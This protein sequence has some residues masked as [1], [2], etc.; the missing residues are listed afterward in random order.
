G[1]LTD[2]ARLYVVQRATG[3]PTAT[4]SLQRTAWKILNGNRDEHVRAAADPTVRR[5]VTAYILAGG[6]SF[7]WSHLKE[8]PERWLD[9][10]EAAKVPI[11]RDA[12]RLAWAAYNTGQMDLAERW[13]RLAP[14]QLM[15]RW[16]RSKLLLRKGKVPEAMA[17]LAIVVR[18][19]PVE[20]DVPMG[21]TNFCWEG[22]QLSLW[23]EPLPERVRGELGTLK[24]SRN[25]YLGALDLFM[26]GGYWDD[27]AYVAECVLTPDELIAVVN[28][29]WP[30]REE[31]KPPVMTR[32]GWWRR[33]T[34]NP[35]IRHLL[36]RRL[37][38]TGR[39]REARRYFPSKW[40][41]RL[42]AY[43]DALRQADDAR[44]D[45]AERAKHLWRAACITR[46]E[47]MELL[48]TEL[49]PDD[50]VSGG[51]FPA[52]TPGWVALPE[53][54]AF[55]TDRR[56][57]L[58]M[59]RDQLFRERRHRVTPYQRFHYRYL[60]CERAWRAAEMMPDDSDATARVLCIAGSWMKG[61]DP[62]YADRFYKALVLRCRGTELGREADRIRWFPKIAVDR[63]KLPE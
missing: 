24:L 38:R 20:D 32:S 21:H 53:S 41:P 46:Y 54:D 34:P 15:A 56:R 45:D 36:A 61:R 40:R 55:F 1:R 43:V 3:D 60:A 14:A 51:A 28:A 30:E 63:R 57:L 39:T 62:L 29:R 9:A 58:R 59:T 26:M 19:V 37:T 12:D 52:R 4:P 22:H 8:L 48:G 2:A 5:V 50:F 49:G 44:L 35:Y 10:V 11:A 27:A 7:R 13:V 17:E 6:G 18:S 23:N 33:A 31:P 42:D 47:G 16:I 25:D